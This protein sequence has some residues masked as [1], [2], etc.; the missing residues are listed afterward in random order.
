[1]AVMES[2]SGKEAGMTFEHTELATEHVSLPVPPT[3]SQGP[4]APRPRKRWITHF[5]IMGY[6]AWLG[7]G[8]LCHALQ[9]R[10]NAH[11]LM[12]FTVWDM[13]C[14]WD[15]WAYRRHI[16]AEGESGK[17][18]E[19][20]PAPW[21]EY[22][23]FG[24]LGREQYDSF[25]THGVA[26]GL[27]CL[28]HTQHE[29]ITRL[30]MIEETWS[31]KFNLPDPFWSQL[32]D[33]EKQ[34]NRYF[35]VKS[36]YRPDGVLLSQRPSFQDNHTS[37]WMTSSLQGRRGADKPLIVLRNSNSGNVLQRPGMLFGN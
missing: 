19:L 27:N 28:A 16:V 23:P 5:V 32:H 35:Y 17:L 11:P 29:P 33:E 9:Y 4:T 12:Y 10:V 22:H 34:I 21:G 31:K 26:I 24:H 6:L 18:Y 8:I 1:M 7:H 30:L 25:R 20:N 2:I 3:T 14:G 13:F 36:I 15:G 37:A